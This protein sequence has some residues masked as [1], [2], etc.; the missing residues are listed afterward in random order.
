LQSGQQ[1]NPTNL[2]LQSLLKLLNGDPEPLTPS[3]SIVEVLPYHMMSGMHR[4]KYCSLVIFP[5]E[6]L[7]FATASGSP[8][9]ELERLLGDFELNA[10]DFAKIVGG[11]LAAVDKYD[12][13]TSPNT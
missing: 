13:Q 8:S 7:S 10:D 4:H 9:L 6:K 12:T 2:S 1:K 11:V 3:K 5:L